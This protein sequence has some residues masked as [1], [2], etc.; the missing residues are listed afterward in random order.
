MRILKGNLLKCDP[1]L[2]QYLLHLDKQ[3]STPFIIADLD[4][5][6]L[7][8]TNRA[9]IEQWIQVRVDEWHDKNSYVETLDEET[10]PSMKMG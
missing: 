5:E 4:A 1:A 3:S 8:I 7:F 10:E 9:D 2:K 6:H